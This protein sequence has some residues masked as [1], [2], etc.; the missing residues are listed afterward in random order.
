MNLGYTSLYMTT[1]LAHEG[2]LALH[3]APVTSD[4]VYLILD[5]HS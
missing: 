5:C 1:Y 4:A 2:H 3:T